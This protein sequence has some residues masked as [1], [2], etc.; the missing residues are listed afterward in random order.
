MVRKTLLSKEDIDEE[1]LKVTDFVK[2]YAIT[3]KE[4]REQSKVLDRLL[5]HKENIVSKQAKQNKKKEA[6]PSYNDNNTVPVYDKVAV[7]KLIDSVKTP[8]YDYHDNIS[9]TLAQDLEGIMTIKRENLPEKTSKG[10]T[11][12]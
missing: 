8:D 11:I 6:K 3:P 1:I 12:T 4:I 2:H 10:N 7:L 9:G 5:E